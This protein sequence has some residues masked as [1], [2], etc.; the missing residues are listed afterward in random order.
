MY[1]SLVGKALQELLLNVL[2]L[3]II[4]GWLCL[5]CQVCLFEDFVLP[6]THVMAMKLDFKSS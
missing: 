1:S 2:F 4:T 3:L 5:I 6:I